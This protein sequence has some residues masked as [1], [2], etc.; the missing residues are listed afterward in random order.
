MA[1]LLFAP[2]FF[3]LMSFP[4]TGMA[5]A[6]V[7]RA[8]QIVAQAL[9]EAIM[10]Q[11]AEAAAVLFSVPVN[12]DGE[13]VSSQDQLRQK[14]DTL[15]Q[16]EGIRTLRLDTVEVIT[17]ETAIERYGPPPSRLGEFSD[18]VI[19]AILTWDRAQLVAFLSQRD[20]RWSIIAVTD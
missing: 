14:C 17:F 9:A 5:E 12:F 8:A 10:A 19:I 4:A 7:S 18:D 20:D 3:V 13:I 2:L 16:I 15:M 11:D 6:R 1:R